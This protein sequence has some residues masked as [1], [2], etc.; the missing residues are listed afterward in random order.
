MSALIKTKNKIKRVL[1]ID[2]FTNIQIIYLLSLCPYSL[3][4]FLNVLIYF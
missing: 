1:V 2:L 4:Y 3:F